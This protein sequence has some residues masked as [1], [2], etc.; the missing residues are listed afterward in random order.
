[1]DN[2]MKTYV[3]P[4][5]SDTNEPDFFWIDKE[6][7][8]AKEDQQERQKY[9]LKLVFGNYWNHWVQIICLDLDSNHGPE[10]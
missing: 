2:E 3:D 6:S 9:Y 7:R 5:T 8:Q 4:N 10:Q 1:M